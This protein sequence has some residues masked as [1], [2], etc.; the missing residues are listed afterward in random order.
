VTFQVKS[1]EGTVNGAP[2]VTIPTNSAGEASVEWTM[3][4]KR[5]VEN[6]VI[7]ASA[8]VARN[9]TI[10]FVAS[11]G[12]DVAF[13]LKSDQSFFQGDVG[14][15]VDPVVVSITDQYGNGVPLFPVTF[16]VQDVQ[17]NM[18]YID[19]PGTTTKTD[20]TDDQ[21][22]VSVNWAL[23]PAPGAQNNKLEASA[24]RQGVHL[25]GSP[26]VFTGSAIAGV[27]D[28]LIKMTDDS[29]LSV[30]VGNAVPGDLRVKVTDHFGNPLAR[31]KVTF[32]VLSR[33]QADGGTLDNNVDSVKVKETNSAGIAS[34]KF[35]AGRRAGVKINKIRAEAI[36]NGQQ[37]VGSPVLFEITGLFSDAR[38]IEIADGNTQKGTVGKFLPDPI[39]VI[40]Y[41]KD[42]NP[43][44]E[45]PV[46][47]KIITQNKNGRNIGALGEGSAIDTTINTDS[48]GIAQV[49]WRMG[50]VVG[51][52]QVQA[53]SEGGDAPLTNSPLTFNAT[54]SADSTN[55]DSSSVGAF[56]PQV[57]VS[58]GSVT[59]EL[60][61]TLR[62]K[63][64]NPVSGNFILLNATGDGNIL[65]QPTQ[66]TTADGQAIGKISSRVA[67][68]KYITARD[69]SDN[70]ALKDS[71]KVTFIPGAAKQIVETQ[72]SG[73]GEQGNIGTVLSKPLRVRVTDNYSNPIANYGIIFTVMENNGILMGASTVTTDSNGVAS[74]YF[75]LG[76]KEG[77][78]RVEARADGLV[79]SP[80]TFNV[81]GRVHAQL[82]SLEKISGDHKSSCPGDEL[83]EM[84]CVMLKDVTNLPVWGESVLFAPLLNDGLIMSENPIATDRYGMAC[85]HANVGTSVGTNVFQASLPNNPGLVATFYDTT[86][87]CNATHIEVYSGDQQKG[88]V[89]FTLPQ[90]LCVRTTD[91]YQNPVGGQNVTFS[92]V[93]DISVRSVGTLE[94]NQRVVNKMSDNRG[95]ACVYYTLGPG[96]G[97][98]KVRARGAGLQPTYVEFSVYGTAGAPYSMEMRSGDNQRGEMGKELLYPVCVTVRDAKGNPT[99][100]GYVEFYVTQGGGSMVGSMP[101][102][103]DANG[104]ACS[105]WQLG[106]RPIGSDN[107]AEAISSNLAGPSQSPIQFKA[108]GDVASWPDFVLPDRIEAFENQQILFQ[109]YATEEDGDFISYRT[110]KLPDSSAMFIM[111]NL[112]GKYEFIWTPA[113]ETVKSPLQVKSFYPVFRAED[114]SGFDVDS[115]EVVVRNVNRPP[116]ITSYT[117]E[118]TKENRVVYT[119]DMLNIPFSVN[120]I[121]PDGDIVYYKWTVNDRFISSDKKFDFIV[122]NYPINMNH[123]VVVEVCDQESCT[124]REWIASTIADVGVELSSFTC[125]AT[126]YEGIILEWKTSMESY[127]AGFHV[128][129]SRTTDGQFFRINPKILLPNADGVYTFRDPLYKAGQKYYYKL[130]DVSKW[131][132]TTDH[133]PIEAVIELPKNYD[134]SQNYPNPFN[135]TTSI[136]FELPKITRVKLEVFN[137]RGE[138]VKK[139][140]DRP[141]EAGYHIAVWDATNNYGVH[142]SSGVYY[143]RISADRFIH[144]KKMAFLK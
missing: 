121:D 115:V 39:E 122:A 131:G 90:P 6:N 86:K 144:V 125:H 28:S 14:Q 108:T 67:G 140:L 8:S 61:V 130:Q 65:Q 100:G 91:E 98:N 72:D 51:K 138:L 134:L 69:M 23:G 135:P 110:I 56:P 32:T 127:N 94:N 63:Y 40:A 33:N 129:R 123:R 81:F 106:P 25:Q 54:A 12:P 95:I 64:G 48:R 22:K 73:N 96:A 105:R 133:G 57:V 109:V 35:Y 103:S 9:K 124:E 4:T 49:L 71:A 102:P 137:I 1:G 10:T 41:D 36:F 19:Q 20:S 11:A 27:P 43:V 5:G 52:Y 83:P 37:L 7:T 66:G 77:R 82:A 46:N 18:G 116:V 141:V 55:A 76:T 93:D 85:V 31:Q 13:A 15:F 50:H 29:N 44:R 84:L 143:Y 120:A 53:S 117:P 75:Q 34:V 126:P 3:G 87:A 60:N 30:K 101:V 62:D 70:I 42:K 21:G 79:G 38:S 142:V 97:L 107:R 136:R 112:T 45:H 16:T 58:D 59:A 74:V 26:R 118:Y 104:K 17:G 99:A 2:Q 111:N 139:L 89:E 88:T 78:N 128:L 80:V 47:F 113:Y 114:R 119:T 68:V 24:K 132:K 92:V